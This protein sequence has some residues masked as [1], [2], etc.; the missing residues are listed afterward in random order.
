MKQ[1][2][3]QSTSLQT[4]TLGGIDLG[5]LFTDRAQFEI[6]DLATRFAYKKEAG[7]SDTNHEYD[8]LK[9]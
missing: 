5:P 4:T 2:L 1:S 3:D 7:S 8:S 6:P 9:V